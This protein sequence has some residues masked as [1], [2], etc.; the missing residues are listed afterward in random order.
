[1]HFDSELEGLQPLEH[2][3]E[4]RDEPALVEQL[5]EVDELGDA[6]RPP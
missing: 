4:V 3:A 6:G 2:D 5:V 1:M